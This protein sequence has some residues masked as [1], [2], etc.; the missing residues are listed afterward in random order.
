MKIAIV[1][2]K[3]KRELVF[4]DRSLSKLRELGEV[5][6][7]D[8]DASL[9]NVK[10]TIKDADIA[11]TSWLNT[12]L[13]A[14]ILDE[15]PNLKLV[16][17]AAGSVKPIVSD[18]LFERGI[19]L[20]ASTKPLGIGVA[21]TSLGFAIS[22]SKNFYQL[23]RDIHSGGYNEN[24]NKVKELYELKV[25]VVSAG[26]VGRHFISLIKNFGVDIL[27]YDPFVSE[28]Q[29]SALGCQKVEFEELLRNS[30]ILSI[31]APSLPETY[32]MFDE[33][34]LS[35]MKTDAVLINTSRG[36]LID[37]TALYNHMKKGN[38]KY[39]CL[40]VYDPEPLLP[41]NPLRTL[42]NVIMTPHIAGLATNGKQRIG[43]HV[44]EQVE[45]FIKGEPLEC[46]VTKEMLP[47]IA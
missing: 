24:L 5:V 14:E 1:A 35:L 29:A 38:L 30:D 8:G 20:V 26:F 23:N 36:A 17:H 39:A 41:E 40:D 18:E 21:E 9:E 12:S 15:C 31:H 2:A 42:D 19:K 22:A 10:K 13:T 11:I 27:L 4:N 3:E 32:H 28:D 33:K 34:A 6:I 47:T 46:V 16:I 37:E 43:A 45:K 7:N 44:A 25:G